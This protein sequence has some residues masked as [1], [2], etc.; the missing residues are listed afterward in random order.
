M[1]RII[2]GVLDYQQLSQQSVFLVQL[3]I[4][5]TKLALLSNIKRGVFVVTSCRDNH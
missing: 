3:H 5:D 4:Y 2:R 1:R